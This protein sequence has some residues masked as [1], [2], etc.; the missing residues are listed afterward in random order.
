MSIPALMSSGFLERLIY[1]KKR[2]PFG[3][4]VRDESIIDAKHPELL[5]EWKRSVTN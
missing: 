1:G 3:I 4:Q 5:A 2:F